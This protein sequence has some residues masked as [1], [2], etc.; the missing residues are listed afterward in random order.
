MQAPTAHEEISLL[1]FI[2]AIS[3]GHGPS[4]SSSLVAKV[5]MIYSNHL[6]LFPYSVSNACITVTEKSEV[7]VAS[8]IDP[9]TPP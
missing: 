3:R 9:G 5:G 4:I 7:T 8:L 1:R 6:D 2:G